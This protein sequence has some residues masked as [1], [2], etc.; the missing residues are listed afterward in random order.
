[1]KK[2][3]VGQVIYSLNVNNAARGRKQELT[4]LTVSSVGRVYFTLEDE[5]GYKLRNRFRIDNWEEDTEYTSNHS[6]YECEQ[7]W[8]DE[9]EVCDLVSEITLEFNHM[10]RPGVKY[11]LQ[12]LRKIKSIID[13]E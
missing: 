5:R 12:Q 2:P 13:G 11:S 4:R 3:E 8:L 9:K 10:A 1:M 7:D 6:L